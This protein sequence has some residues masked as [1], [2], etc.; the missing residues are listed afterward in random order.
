MAG[1]GSA[2]DIYFCI[3]AG[4]PE[5]YKCLY[6]QFQ[7]IQHCLPFSLFCCFSFSLIHIQHY[8]KREWVRVV[9]QKNHKSKAYNKLVL[10]LITV[11][12][13]ILKV[14]IIGI[15]LLWHILRKYS[16]IYFLAVPIFCSSYFGIT[17]SL[18]SSPKECFWCSV[19]HLNDF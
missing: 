2:V 10:F 1:D 17:V 3:R 18:A 8:K 16:W 6:A 19:T 13:W 11:M 9:I 15:N 14:S 5:T 12:S 7:G 4:S